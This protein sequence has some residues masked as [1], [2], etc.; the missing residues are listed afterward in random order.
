[1]DAPAEDFLPDEFGDFSGVGAER[2]AADEVLHSVFINPLPPEDDG[3]E[4]NLT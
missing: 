3:E 2:V 4:C 1:V